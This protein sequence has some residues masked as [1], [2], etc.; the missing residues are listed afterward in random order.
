MTKATNVQAA[1]TPSDLTR[2]NLAATQAAIIAAGLNSN[3]G[4]IFVVDGERFVLFNTVTGLSLD[5]EI[6]TIEVDASTLEFQE[7][8]P[9]ERYTNLLDAVIK[10]G[11]TSDKAFPILHMFR[12]AYL[13]DALPFNEDGTIDIEKETRVMQDDIVDRPEGQ[14]H[15]MM[16]KL[17]E[18]MGMGASDSDD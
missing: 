6:H 12:V 17:A 4:K 2:D 16:A 5:E 3:V 1:T 9:E 15:M 18:I 7:A 11:L 8:T 14:K 13:S 10:F